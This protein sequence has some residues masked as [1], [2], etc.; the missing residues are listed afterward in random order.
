MLTQ[1]GPQ[2]T[3]WGTLPGGHLISSLVPI[4]SSYDLTIFG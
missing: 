2:T 4:N 1:G 3:L